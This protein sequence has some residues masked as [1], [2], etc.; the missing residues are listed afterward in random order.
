MG[1]LW[2]FSSSASSN[3]AQ[4]QSS[5]NDSGDT[6]QPSGVAL[7]EEQRLRIFGRPGPVAAPQKPQTQEEKADAELEALINSFAAEANDTKPTPSSTQT[8][9][10][11][12]KPDPEPS[13]ILPD[14][15]LD[16]SPEAIYP[17]TMSCRQQFDQAF[18]CQSLGGKFNDIYR[19][20]HLNS[21]SEQ[22]GA[23]WFCMRNRTLPEEQKAKAIKEFYRERDERRKRERGSSEDVWEIRKVAV[24]R[25]FGEDPDKDEGVK[26]RE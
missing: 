13:R 25:A 7:S 6:S 4:T 9:T 16:I 14:G 12:Q 3:E 17:R 19:Y 26:M 22:W 21:C 5:N 2:P 24:E 15:S 18:Y 10:Q 11:P 23:F 8:Q 1:W 20:G